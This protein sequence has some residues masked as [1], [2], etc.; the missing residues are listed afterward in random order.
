MPNRNIN[1]IVEDEVLLTIAYVAANPDISSEERES[2]V[3]GAYFKKKYNFQPY[4]FH[5]AYTDADG[6]STISQ[7]F[8][9]LAIAY[10]MTNPTFLTVS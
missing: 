3:N 4:K 7:K 2:Q 6:K 1:A 8:M 9:I 5:F 10:W